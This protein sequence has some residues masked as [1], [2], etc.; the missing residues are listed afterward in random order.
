MKTMYATP[1]EGT[2]S[3]KTRQFDG[4]F[5]HKQEKVRVVGE[6][7]RCYI[8]AAYSFIRGHKPGEHIQVKRG[9]VTIAEPMQ[10]RHTADYSSAWWNN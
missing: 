5:L 8:I 1:K 9:N 2:Y 3:L 10:E 7:E 6:T 4:T